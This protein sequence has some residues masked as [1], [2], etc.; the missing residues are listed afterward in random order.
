[1]SHIRDLSRLTYGGYK[2]WSRLLWVSLGLNVKSD[3]SSVLFLVC[4]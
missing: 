4:D 1:M 2:T 3:K